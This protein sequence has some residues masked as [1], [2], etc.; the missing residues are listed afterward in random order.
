[1]KPV[2]SFKNFLKIGIIPAAL[3]GCFVA[4]NREDYRT[5]STVTFSMGP[6]TNAVA[7]T[8]FP[9]NPI[10]LTPDK[11]VI[12]AEKYLNEKFGATN[13]YW[14]IEGIEIRRFG[15]ATP[16]FYS[17]DLVNKSPASP[18]PEVVRV[19]LN[20]EVWKPESESKY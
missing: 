17:I 16:W 10:P 14:E 5:G 3:L 1:M 8:W 20:G 19:L 9:T 6:L 11:A 7:P 15:P 18:P 12:I 2:S 13:I 4:C